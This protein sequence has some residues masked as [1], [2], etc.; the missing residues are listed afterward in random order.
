AEIAFT[1]IDG[2]TERQKNVGRAK[3]DTRN[4][5]L[6]PTTGNDLG[7]VEPPPLVKFLSET[8]QWR[9]WIGRTAKDQCDLRLASLSRE[10][11]RRSTAGQGNIVVVRREEDVAGGRKD[12]C[13]VCQAR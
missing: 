7:R 10:Q 5:F 4:R 6:C 1:A 12:R 8:R 13:D 9:H 2:I 3:N 11:R